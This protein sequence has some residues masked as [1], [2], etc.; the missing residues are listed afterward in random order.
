LT[1]WGTFVASEEDYVAVAFQLNGAK[2]RV[3]TRPDRTLLDIL[4]D[5]LG[6]TA[7]KP[8]CTIGRCGACLVLVDGQPVNSC[9]VMAF[10]LEGAIVI[11]PEG[12][13]SVFEAKFV[14]EALVAENSFQCGYCAPGFTIALVALL[15]RDRTP[16]ETAIRN[17]L[18]GNLCRCTGYQS[19]L[20]GARTAIERLKEG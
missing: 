4:R 19:I 12:L 16:N 11:S 7:A 3:V 2:Q 9:L 14:R 20:R 13:D 8:G 6:L 5:T 15:R 1:P 18:A 10:Q 17:S